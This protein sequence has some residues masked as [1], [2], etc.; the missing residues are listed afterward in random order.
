MLGPQKRVSVLEYG[1]GD[2]RLKVPSFF[3]V[4]K[5]IFLVLFIGIFFGVNSHCDYTIIR[6]SSS[7]CQADI[8]TGRRSDK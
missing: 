2:K 8:R 6:R 1:A 3:Y 5:A 7:R 4:A